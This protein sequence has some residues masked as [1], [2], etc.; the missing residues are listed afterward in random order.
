MASNKN[1]VQVFRVR[2]VEVGQIE[3]NCR[4]F[5][6]ARLD[7]VSAICVTLCC[8]GCRFSFFLEQAHA[9]KCIHGLGEVD[10]PCLC[11][12]GESEDEL[13][14]RDGTRFDILI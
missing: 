9:R 4:R 1:P 10:S 3:Q 8:I 14:V 6:L 11:V 2:Q 12:R 13:T 5:R 7:L